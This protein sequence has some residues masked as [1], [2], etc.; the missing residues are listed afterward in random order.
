[1]EA[2]C[3]PER[4]RF[5]NE[6]LDSSFKDIEK[7]SN[8]VNSQMKNGKELLINQIKIS[9]DLEQSENINPNKQMNVEYKRIRFNRSAKDHWSD[10]AIDV[11]R[12]QKIGMTTII[13]SEIDDL[14]FASK[15]SISHGVDENYKIWEWDEDNIKESEAYGLENE[16]FMTFKNPINTHLDFN[17]LSINGK[18]I[19]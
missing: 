10:G 13:D 8:I 4:P 14:I 17:G 12:L 1:M 7:H 11:S 18:N 3:S 6:M 15:S 9:L 2:Q 19:S 5:H 16:N